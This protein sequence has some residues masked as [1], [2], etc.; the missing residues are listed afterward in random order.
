VN[1]INPWIILK[2]AA[3]DILATGGAE[4]PQNKAG[5]AAQKHEG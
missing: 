5:E 4:H 3:L 2:S 1:N